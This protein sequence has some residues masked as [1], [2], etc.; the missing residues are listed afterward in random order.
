MQAQPP[1]AAADIPTAAAAF[2]GTPYRSAASVSL[3]RGDITRLAAGAIVNAA[4]SELLVSNWSRAGSPL[5][6]FLAS[7]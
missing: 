1:V 3:W 7:R 6:F 2:P 4:N 5:L